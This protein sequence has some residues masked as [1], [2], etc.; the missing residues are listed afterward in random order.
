M[1]LHDSSTRLRRFLRLSWADHLLLLEAILWLGLA[2]AA[3]LS[4]SFRRIMALLQQEQGL[5]A[6]QANPAADAPCQRV[7]WAIRCASRRTP[8]LSNCL[9]QALTGKIMLRRRGIASTL[10]LGVAKGGQNNLA[11]HAW[12]RS[13]EII[14]TG[15]YNLAQYTVIA[16]FR[17]R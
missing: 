17:D 10:Y 14:L 16:S 11:A 3:V 2:R 6:D 9:A 12:L 8:W 5:T 15:G 1:I 7:G 4:I 13:G